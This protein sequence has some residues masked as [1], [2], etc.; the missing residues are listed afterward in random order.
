MKWTISR[1]LAERLRA[2]AKAAG[3]SEI[4]GLLLG[5]EGRIEAAAPVP[6]VAPDPRRAFLLD[7]ATHLRVSREAR[8]GGTRIIGCYHSHPGGD[9]RPSA[10]DAAHAAEQGFHWLILADDGE[11]LWRSR[12]GGPV[13]GAFEPVALEIA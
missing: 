10:L 4:C 6:N 2:E 3:K 1:G 9:P 8:Q 11:T 13:A 12:T 7:P 5:R